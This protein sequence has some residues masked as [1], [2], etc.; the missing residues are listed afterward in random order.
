MRDRNTA[1]W[2]LI[3]LESRRRCAGYRKAIDASIAAIEEYTI[4]EGIFQVGIHGCRIIIVELE[5]KTSLRIIAELINDRIKWQVVC[6]AVLIV[7]AG[8]SLFR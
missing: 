3:Q 7:H 1:H 2:H 5:G 6:A 8:D 4:L